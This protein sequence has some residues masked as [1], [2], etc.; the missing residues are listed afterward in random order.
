MIDNVSNKIEFNKR[1][2]ITNYIITFY[3]GTLYIY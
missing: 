1:Y 3:K 2:R